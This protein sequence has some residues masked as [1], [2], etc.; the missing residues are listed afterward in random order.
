LGYIVGIAGNQ[1]QEARQALKEASFEVDFILP[2]DLV[3]AELK[4]TPRMDSCPRGIHFKINRFRA[5]ADSRRKSRRRDWPKTVPFRCSVPHQ[6]HPAAAQ[7]YQLQ[8]LP[9]RSPGACD[10]DGVAVS[11]CVTVQILPGLILGSIEPVKL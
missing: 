5:G 4:S 3:L 6:E 7:V 1:P 8:P 10:E 9:D 11:L 2:D